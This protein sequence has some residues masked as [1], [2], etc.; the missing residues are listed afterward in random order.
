LFVEGFRGGLYFC[1]KHY[2]PLIFQLYRLL[3]ALAMVPALL[4]SLLFYPFLKNK[5]KLGAFWQIFQL[6]LKGGPL[7]GPGRR[8]K[9][10][11]VSNGHAED[12]AAAAIGRELK[13]QAEVT[14][15][16]LVGKGGAYDQAGIIN[17]GVKK[18]LPSGGF[19]KEG[20]GYFL[21]D[22]RAGWFGH[23]ARHISLLRQL[24]GS[25]DLAVA[26]GDLYLVALCGLFLQRPLIFVD[27]P[28]SVKIA[29]YWPLELWLMRKF[30]QRIVVQDQA[31]ADH[32]AKRGLPAVYLGS[33]VMD[34]VQPTGEKFEFLGDQTVIGIL[35]GSREEAYDNLNLALAV[36]DELP[37]TVGLVASVLDRE[38]IRNKIKWQLAN[39]WLTSPKGNKVYLAEG[40]FADVCLRAK[41]IIGL[42]G[43]ANEQAVALGRP[44]VSFV[45]RGAQTTLRRWQEIQKITGEAMIILSGSAPEKAARIKRLLDDPLLLQE[46][47]RIGR[48]SKPQWGGIKKIAELAADSAR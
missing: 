27:G 10:L 48:E 43:I 39:N 36:M 45:G 42:A 26:V 46:M 1:R 19:A 40:K 16:A 34:Y 8:K 47:A 37:G 33:W 32:L 23:L 2:G 31:T 5:G 7:A 24:R 25:V 28:K 3:L 30:C 9:I 29:G 11:L 35:P 14:G 38:K 44:I 15:L 21:R 41:L 4:F 18:N 13:D 22:L 12:L 20:L 6:A 17:L